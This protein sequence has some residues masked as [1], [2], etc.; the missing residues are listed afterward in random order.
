MVLAAMR[1]CAMVNLSTGPSRLVFPRAHPSQAAGCRPLPFD[2]GLAQR[3]Q[4]REEALDYRV[5]SGR[6]WAEVA[7]FDPAEIDALDQMWLAA[8]RLGL[9]RTG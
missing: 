3:A 4:E 7:R 5:P 1:G 8:A 9:A 2:A 6:Y